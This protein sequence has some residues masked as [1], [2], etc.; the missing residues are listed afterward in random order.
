MLIKDLS[1]IEQTEANSV[2]GGFAVT[3]ADV[4]AVGSKA[5]ADAFAF[6][7]GDGTGANTR[8]NTYSSRTPYFQIGTATAAATAYGVNRDGKNSSVDTSVSTGVAT[9]IFG[10]FN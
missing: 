7:A 9:S 3:S 10:G 2:N 1:F 5:G 6:G 8:T 4:Y